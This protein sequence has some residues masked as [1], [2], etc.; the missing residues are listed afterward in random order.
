MGKEKKR[1]KEED[2]ACWWPPRGGRVWIREGG[3]VMVLMVELRGA[4]SREFTWWCVAVPEYGGLRVYG[5][6]FLMG[7][8]FSR[9]LSAI[10]FLFQ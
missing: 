10:F 4:G 5:I 3:D 9:M 1:K 8:Y 7:H 6:N 2:E